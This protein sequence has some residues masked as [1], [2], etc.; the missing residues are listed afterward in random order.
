[1]FS[2]SVS[3]Q[4]SGGSIDLSRSIRCSIGYILIISYADVYIRRWMSDATFRNDQQLETKLG[5]RNRSCL[6][7]RDVSS[8]ETDLDEPEVRKYYVM[9]GRCADDVSVLDAIETCHGVRP[10]LLSDR[11][12]DRRLNISGIHTD[13]I[14]CLV[15]F[16]FLACLP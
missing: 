3:L 11:F 14:H 10:V 5:P 6:V 15:Q 12:I 16:L 9:S 4:A 7:L 8:M 1:M 13:F 2:R